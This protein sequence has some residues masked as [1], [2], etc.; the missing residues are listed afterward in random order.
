MQ[1]AVLLSCPNKAIVFADAVS[2]GSSGM[3]G[4]TKQG[5]FMSRVTLNFSLSKTDITEITN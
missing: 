3:F 5:V 4:I 2:E 1:K